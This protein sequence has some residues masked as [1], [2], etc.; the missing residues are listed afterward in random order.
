MEQFQ[1]MIDKMKTNFFLISTIILILGCN[2]NNVSI[3]KWQL[4]IEKNNSCIKNLLLYQENYFFF[5]LNQNLNK[6]YYF[7]FKNLDEY[8]L[9]SSIEY[10]IETFNKGDKILLDAGYAVKDGICF[11]QSEIFDEINFIYRIAGKKIYRFRFKLSNREW[12]YIAE[13]QKDARNSG[14]HVIQGTP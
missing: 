5:S 4:Q 9:N 10:W 11:K 14:G 7:F 3:Q 6:F 8:M 12:I 13:Q 1:S 2:N